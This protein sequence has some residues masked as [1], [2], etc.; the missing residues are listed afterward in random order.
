VRR[1]H[2]LRP[3]AGVIRGNPAVVADGVPDTR[4]ETQM[5]HQHD[6]GYLRG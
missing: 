3:P 4:A 6:A 5:S 2:H 1:A